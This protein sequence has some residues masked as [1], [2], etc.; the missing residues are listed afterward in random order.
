M[1][2]DAIDVLLQSLR[3]RTVPGDSAGS[4]RPARL[5]NPIRRTYSSSSLSPSF[6]PVWM[7]P[8]LLEKTR[9]SVSGKTP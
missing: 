1:A 9:T 6:S 4:G 2:T 7:A 8:M 5:P 3:S